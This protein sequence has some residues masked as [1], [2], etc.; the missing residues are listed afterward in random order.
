MRQAGGRRRT[1]R[2]A[3]RRQGDLKLL[4]AELRQYLEQ[5]RAYLKNPQ[6][7]TPEDLRHKM[8]YIITLAQGV[9]YQNFDLEKDMEL[10]ESR[11]R[12][13]HGLASITSRL[14]RIAELA[15][16]VVRQFG[17]LSEPS[18][19]N[20]YGL[21]DFFDE[22]D[23]GLAMI[24]PALEQQKLKMVVRLCQV[25]ERLDALYADRFVRLIKEMD[26]GLGAPGDRVTTLMVVHYLERIGDL[27]LEIGEEMI[28]VILGEA[29]RFGQYQAL[30]AGLKASGYEGVPVVAGDFHS[31]WGGRSGCRVGVVD[32]DDPGASVGEPLIFKHGP[33]V[34]LEK[35][36]SNLQTWAE[37]W[38]GLPPKVLAFIPPEND[39]QAAMVLEYIKGATL[40]DMFLDPLL[41][42][43]AREE[44]AAALNL[45]ARLW[46]ET[47]ADQE[48]RAGFV[49][50][51]EKR[52]GSVRA[53]YPDLVDFNG[54]FG[55][56]KIPSMADIL[57]E[58]KIYERDLAAPFS[59]RVH[60]DFNLSNIM[61]DEKTGA[62]RFIDLYRSCLSDYSQD[63][64]V[65]ILSLLRLPLG[66]VFDRE[67]LG[68]AAS[69]VWTFALDFAD[70]V[71]DETLE[72]R[73]SFGLARSYLTSA[74]FEPRRR[75]AARFLG[76]SRHLWL[77][78]VEYGRTGRPWADFKLDKKSLYV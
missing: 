7:S 72:A 58:A 57:D 14:H 64:S 47:M 71:N 3:R 5:V 22:I 28:Y 63:L 24:R 52:L 66:G 38:P 49:R 65:L 16:N 59:V 29:L 61:R 77:K 78:L 6:I 25:E 76:Y 68:A 73:L 50:Q 48:T 69:F 45:M 56:L 37:L 33:A 67:R 44:L 15:H 10:D 40:K 53:L 20:D 9:R 4:L 60:G 70:S 74:R 13:H 34:K 18:F 42:G 75:V 62:L 12:F 17:H 1:I 32:V 21:L 23:L 11:R 36:K 30:V 8:A 43:G 41:A 35:E 51:A 54:S 46:R 39:G 27:I 55:R 19:L 31:I 26:Q 2:N